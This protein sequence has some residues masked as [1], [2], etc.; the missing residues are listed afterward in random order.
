M[1][2]PIVFYIV[3]FAA[4]IPISTLREGGWIFDLNGVNTPWYEYFTLFGM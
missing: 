2:V 3:V 4:R 1:L